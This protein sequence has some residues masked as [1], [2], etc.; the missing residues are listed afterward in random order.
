MTSRRYGLV[1]ESVYLAPLLLSGLVD[2]PR[3]VSFG[4]VTGLAILSIAYTGA[5]WLYWWGYPVVTVSVLRAVWP[6]LLFL[7]WSFL[8]FAWYAPTTPGLQNLIVIS[9]FVGLILL[10]ARQIRHRPRMAAR[11]ARVL[12]WS[13]WLAVGLY[14][15]GIL[16]GGLGSDRI[17]GPRPFALFALIGLGWYLASWRN[18]SRRGFWAAV[19]IALVIAASLSRLAFVVALLSFPLSQVRLRSIRGWT[20]LVLWAALMTGVL[21]LT[22]TYFEPVRARFF[23]GDLSFRIGG[24]AINA[25][26]R[27]SYWRATL[28][29]FAE[30]P[31][32]GKGAGSSQILIS[33]RWGRWGVSHPHN[34]YLRLLHDY[35][36]IGLGLWLLGLGCVTWRIWRAW[37]RNDRKCPTEARLHM[38][39][40]L[41][42]VAM[43][44]AMITDNTVVYAFAMAPLGVVVG[45]SLGLVSS[46]RP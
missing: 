11:T 38:T 27:S 41:S 22:L 12:T 24:I 33:S 1:L 31:W 37:M 23:Q 32:I 30:S 2:L 21:Y 16:L 3:T 17:L 7:A 46:G 19:I 4:Q 15:L 26:G 18:G 9:A 10:S 14:G 39:A 25:M 8:S 13:T 34:D 28:E 36:A 6:L 44:L 20:R 43:S 42:L 5:G 29:S 40:F 35:G 45:T